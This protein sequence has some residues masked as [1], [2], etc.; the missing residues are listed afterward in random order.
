MIKGKGRGCTMEVKPL[1]TRWGSLKCGKCGGQLSV[2]AMG[3]WIA[4]NCP[5]CGTVYTLPTPGLCSGPGAAT[6]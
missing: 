6:I 2:V 1:K 3:K 4:V 5:D